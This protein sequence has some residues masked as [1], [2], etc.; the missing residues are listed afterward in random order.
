MSLM[1]INELSY[2]ASMSSHIL[3]QFVQVLVFCLLYLPQMVHC[4]VHP[5]QL[6]YG[7]A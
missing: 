7:E 2:L 5:L 6:L 1:I 3:H 4:L